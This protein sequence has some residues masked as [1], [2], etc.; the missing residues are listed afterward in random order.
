MLKE[1]VQTVHKSNLLPQLVLEWFS[2]NGR[3]FPW[4]ESREPYHIIIAE[5]LLRRTQA[6]R[7]VDSYL[8]LIKEYPNPEALSKADLQELHE[9]FRPLGLVKRAETLVEI[10]N[11]IMHNYKGQIPNKISEIAELPGMGI[12]GSHALLCLA[13]NEKVPMIDESSGRLLRRVYNLSTEGPA[14]SDKKLL[15]TAKSIVPTHYSREFN[16]GLLDI[17]AAFCHSKTPDCLNCPLTEVCSH[18]QANADFP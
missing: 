6:K 10:S 17:A 13:F 2:L 14:Y 3:S 15:Q 9:I 12:Y 16:L 18:Y 11:R 4:R 5:I 7:V 8:K 1:G